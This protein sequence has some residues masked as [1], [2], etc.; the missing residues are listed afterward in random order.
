MDTTG[1][2]AKEFDALAWTT[3]NSHKQAVA[4]AL[5][6][7]T[8][9]A[10][11][12]SKIGRFRISG[13]LGR[14]GMGQ[15]LAGFDAQLERKVAIKL[16]HKEIGAEHSARLEREAKA[17]AKLSHPNVVQVYEVGIHEDRLFVA[18]E[19]VKGATLRAWLG[20]GKRSVAEV[21]ALF[22]AAGR[23][24]AAAHDAGLIHR[25][26]KPDNVLVGDDGRPRV[27]D[28]G[29][30]REHWRRSEEP[31]PVSGPPAVQLDDQ[32]DD[33]LDQLDDQLGWLDTRQP[34]MLTSVGA[35]LGTPAYMSPE[36]FM[37]AA[38][39][40]ATDQF[41]FCVAL[42]E[43]LYGERPF[44]GESMRA[45]AA[46]VLSGRIDAAKHRGPARL[47]RAVE[48]GLATDVERRWPDMDALLAELEHIRTAPLRRKRSAVVGVALA[49]AAFTGG[50]SLL[51][52]PAGVTSVAG[53]GPIACPPAAQ[54]TAGIW[55]DETRARL[56]SRWGDGP[57]YIRQWWQFESTML[58]D[59]VADW[60][61]I[62]E[63][64]CGGE[65]KT[66]PT[67]FALRMSCLDQRIVEIRTRVRLMDDIDPATR[68]LAAAVEYP[69]LRL[70]AE[71]E[72]EGTLQSTPLMPSDPEQRDAIIDAIIE[73]RVA[74]GVAMAAYVGDRV[75]PDLLDQGRAAIAAV[76]ET[77][78]HPAVAETL[79][80]V[81]NA[82]IVAGVEMELGFARLQR[83][84]DLARASRADVVW[85]LAEGWSLI[86][87]THRGTRQYAS[88]D[89]G[90]LLDELAMAA[91]RMGDPTQS[92][93]SVLDLRARRAVARGDGEKLANLA[94]EIERIAVA[95]Y[96]HRSYFAAHQ[97]ER[98]AGRLA[99]LG[100]DALARHYRERALSIL[101]AGAGRGNYYTH[102]ILVELGADDFVQGRWRQGENT[103][104]RAIA[105]LGDSFA[106]GE[107]QAVEVRATLAV[108][109]ALRG[110]I[111]EAEQELARVPLSARNT[112]PT[113]A[114]A[115][116]VLA[117]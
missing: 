5:F 90:R 85:V 94:E 20:D 30:A 114:E 12:P 78:F 62:Y 45:L 1:R 24:L 17:L 95:G 106:V 31:D 38:T 66:D 86:H 83:A 84:K 99:R 21:L 116:A 82:Q 46:A 69:P 56:A 36:Q 100:E 59:W 16:L 102:T 113:W 26:F 57:A 32:L 65:S 111:A 117:A 18:M 61:R 101:E 27:L 96:G 43:A 44:G 7:P 19:L 74:E 54:R 91:K 92:T 35:I 47:R 8:G 48:R 58:D 75:N 4:G 13:E 72:L 77:Q 89:V 64:S 88:A 6:G 52:D 67:R 37:G 79:F 73:L 29:L 25:D 39:S 28:F 14:G 50:W 55:D 93:L 9:P 15:V 68:A 33:Q 110:S 71:C 51:R 60:T 2:I 22:V 3:V 107:T 42:W 97:I 23:G 87:D 49:I 112:T 81:G 105:I 104:R 53:S 115:H 11:A 109:L 80:R 63:G 103:V 40:P 108:A 70:P 76:S 41:S 10:S 34:T 98:V